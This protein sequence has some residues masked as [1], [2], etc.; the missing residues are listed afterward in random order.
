[1]TT[2]DELQEYALKMRELQQELD[3]LNKMNKELEDKF[4]VIVDVNGDG[5]GN[6]DGYENA[7]TMDYEDTLIQKI[8][9]VQQSTEEL[10]KSQAG[11]SSSE[12]GELTTKVAVKLEKGEV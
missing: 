12:D 3:N 9:E 8:R 6:G 5:D 4:T 11:Q 10:V 7:R 2:E 1:M